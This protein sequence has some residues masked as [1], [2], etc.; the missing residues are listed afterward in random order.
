MGWDD[1]HLNRFRVHGRNYGIAHIRG[2][3]LDEDAAAVPLS[4]FGFRPTERCP[5]EY[6]FTA[7]WQVE[8]RVGQVIEETS[9]ENHR[10]AGSHCCPGTR[11]CGRMR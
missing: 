4:Q 10:I 11:S 7:G 1:D 2:V 9:C 5:C 6:N 8:V 3:N